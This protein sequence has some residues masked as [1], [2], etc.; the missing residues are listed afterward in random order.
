MEV[1]T[2]DYFRI[3]V[4]TKRYLKEW[5]I[6]RLQVGP[7]SLQPEAPWLG[8]RARQY[9]LWSVS[10]NCL[11]GSWLWQ[12][13]K[14]SLGLVERREAPGDDSKAMERR[15]MTFAASSW[16]DC[17][18]TDV[19]PQNF[20]F[21]KKNDVTKWNFDAETVKC[22][23]MPKVISRSIVCTDTKDKE[24]YEGDTP[25]YVYLCVCGQL[26]LILGQLS[27]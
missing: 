17:R 10:V 22:L 6:S 4:A 5:M 23:K 16:L 19:Y 15:N 25:L 8:S 13:S 27:R 18:L 12:N 26:A 11:L 21:S 2:N 20:K 14:A 3:D 1:S 7:I 9:S 24:E